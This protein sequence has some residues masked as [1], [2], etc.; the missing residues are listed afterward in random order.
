M[1]C[2]CMHVGWS[3]EAPPSLATFTSLLKNDFYTMFGEVYCRI[4]SLS[5]SGVQKSSSHGP[6]NFIHHWCWG[7]GES[8]RGDFSLQRWW[9]IKSVS[10]TLW[11]FQRRVSNC[12]TPAKTPKACWKCC[13]VI[14]WRKIFGNRNRGDKPERFWEGN[15]PLR[16]SLRGG[17]VF[18]GF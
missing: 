17:G 18:R 10:D 16:G 11:S 15:L 8:V 4:F 5:S 14:P 7:G 1:P 9:C 3:H 2:S 13:Q 6:R 12:I